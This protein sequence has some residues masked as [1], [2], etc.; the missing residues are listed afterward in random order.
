MMMMMM[1]M[2]LYA[3][4]SIEQCHTRLYTGILQRISAP[5]MTVLK[6]SALSRC[7]LPPD[8]QLSVTLCLLHTVNVPRLVIEQKRNCFGVWHGRSPRRGAWRWRCRGW[9]CSN[10]TVMAV[11]LSVANI[12][13]LEAAHEQAAEEA[14]A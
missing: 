11:S 6:K 13:A 12:S 2:I 3:F 9:R 4:C 1:V 8:T 10:C 14:R 5:Q 7:P